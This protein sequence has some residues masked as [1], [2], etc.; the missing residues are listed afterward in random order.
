MNQISKVRSALPRDSEEFQYVR[1]LCVQVLWGVIPLGNAFLNAA[2]NYCNNLHGHRLQNFITQLKQKGIKNI[3][4][5][6]EDIFN[7]APDQFV[8]KTT[9]IRNLINF[10]DSNND[11]YLINLLINWENGKIENWHHFVI[12]ITLLA[13]LDSETINF[14]QKYVTKTTI[15]PTNVNSEKD[16][17]YIAHN[18]FRLGLIDRRFDGGFEFN[19]VARDLDRFALSESQRIYEKSKGDLYDFGEWELNP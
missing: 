4:D 12:L 15:Y 16:F 18:L 3:K 13:D 19:E 5:E 6:L 11:S 9:V 17:G 14:I 7:K 10:Q 8:A 2:R 1:D